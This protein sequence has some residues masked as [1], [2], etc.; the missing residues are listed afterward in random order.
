[1]K[2]ILA[3]SLMIAMAMTMCVSSFA[4]SGAFVQSPS[5]NPTP[6]IED[7][8]PSDDDCTAEV[9]VTPYSDKDDL[10]EE[11]KERIEEMYEQITS[12]DD[13]TKLFDELAKLAEELGI[14]GNDL[15]VSDLFNIH[16]EGC[17][18]H[19]EHGEFD[20]T[21]SAD[22]LERFVALI[23]LNADGKWE[24]VDGAKVTNNGEHLKFNFN[25]AGPLAIVVN[26]GSDK[27][28]DT[29]STATTKAPDKATQ[30]GDFSAI[31]TV[32]MVASAMAVAVVAT[33]S[34]KQG[35]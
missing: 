13:L 3:I 16:I 22:T 2:K 17:T 33:K 28:V 29:S 11:F 9:I 6:G 32:V 25:S 14:D 7:V 5:L 34:K 18:N 27:P 19:D 20:I 12:T 15:A 30:T 10:P 26:T 8:D 1:M 23:H 21:L 24:I 4:A 35:I 31:F